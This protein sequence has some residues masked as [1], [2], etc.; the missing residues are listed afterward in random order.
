MSKVVLDMAISLDGIVAATDGSDNGMY[1]WYFAEGDDSADVKNELLES[2]GA[3]ILGKGAF[4]DQPGW[5]RY[6]IQGAP[7]RSLSRAERNRV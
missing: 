6:A 3:M 4:G 5:L 2:V 7:L 1:D